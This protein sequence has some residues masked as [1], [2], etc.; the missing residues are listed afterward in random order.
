MNTF[1][2]FKLPVD[3]LFKLP[4]IHVYIYLYKCMKTRYQGVDC[5]DTIAVYTLRI[6]PHS[7]IRASDR[8]F[9]SPG[10][11]STRLDGTRILNVHLFS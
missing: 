2:L 5:T 7:P 11:N 8:N 3:Q 10:S 1:S 9:H 6:E 4:I